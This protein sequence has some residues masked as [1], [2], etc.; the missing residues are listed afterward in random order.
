MDAL[1]YVKILETVGF[2]RE[3]SEATLSSFTE[4]MND[5]LATKQDIEQLQIATKHDIERLQIATKHDIEQ[6]KMDTKHNLEMLK[7][8]LTIKLGMMQA[9]SVGLIV[10][11]LK[12]L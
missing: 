1:K 7:A 9:A 2:S 6:L 8:E 4:F 12:I 3:Q 11:L 10:A 5:N